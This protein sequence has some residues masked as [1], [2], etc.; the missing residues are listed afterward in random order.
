MIMRDKQYLKNS[1]NVNWICKKC[2]KVENNIIILTLVHTER[3][4]WN[5]NSF[6][7]I[8]ESFK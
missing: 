7:S 2:N 3:G 6:Q 8:N 4:L 1:I 5:Q